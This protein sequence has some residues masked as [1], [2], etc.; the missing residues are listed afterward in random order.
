MALD[1]TSPAPSRIRLANAV[2]TIGWLYMTLLFVVL[3]LKGFLSQ[4]R[5]P[6]YLYVGTA[7][8]AALLVLGGRLAGNVRGVLL[9]ALMWLALGAL[10]RPFTGAL[11]WASLNDQWLIVVLLL[12]GAGYV[13]SHKMKFT[14]EERNVG[15]SAI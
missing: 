12:V 7:V 1:T 5:I 3:M 8:A 11:S 4:P 14:I 2:A 15:E 6:W 10:A 9:V 13:S